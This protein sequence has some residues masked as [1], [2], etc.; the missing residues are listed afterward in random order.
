MKIR[1]NGKEE[2]IERTGSLADLVEEKAFKSESTVIEHNLEVVP[3]EKWTQVMLNDGDRLEIV[4]F[5][6]GG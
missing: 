1:I 4:S 6:G 2:T 5:V 3:R